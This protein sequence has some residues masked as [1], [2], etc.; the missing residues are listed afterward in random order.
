[1]PHNTGSDHEEGHENIGSKG[2]NRRYR[3]RGRVVMAFGCREEKLLPMYR[4]P[5][6]SLKS[7]TEDVQ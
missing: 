4:V 1:M 6:E 3:E 7:E 5:C 2:E